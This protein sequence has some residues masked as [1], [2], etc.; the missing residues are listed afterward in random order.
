MNRSYK[1]GRCDGTGKVRK[2]T[3]QQRDRRDSVEKAIDGAVG[4]L[5]SLIG[6]K[7]TNNSNSD[8]LVKCPSCGGSGSIEEDD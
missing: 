5:G 3:I 1:C 4:F 6:A 8:E 7:T 2:K